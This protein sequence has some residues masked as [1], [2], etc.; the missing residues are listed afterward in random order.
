[1]RQGRWRNERTVNGYIEEAQ[2]FEANAA[3]SI[4][5]GI[6]SSIILTETSSE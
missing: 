4:L 3:E 5:D 6:K 1:M 2:L